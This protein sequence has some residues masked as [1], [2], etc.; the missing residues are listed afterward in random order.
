LPADD[1]KTVDDIWAVIVQKMPL[2]M[3]SWNPNS[4]ESMGLWEESI[5]AIRTQF[6]T[7]LEHPNRKFMINRFV[8]KFGRHGPQADFAWAIALGEFGINFGAGKGAGLYQERNLQEAVYRAVQLEVA[9]AQ[10]KYFLQNPALLERYCHF[11]YWGEWMDAGGKMYQ[12]LKHPTM[13][14]LASGEFW[15][16]A[17]DFLVLKLVTDSPCPEGTTPNML[18]DIAVRWN[19]VLSSVPPK[20]NADLP[21]PDWRGSDP[22][23]GPD[24]SGY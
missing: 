20:Y 8:R 12:T 18:Y 4:Q 2:D 24:L 17:R 16:R 6:L 5:L 3:P 10:M 11:L 9:E 19:E 13:S 22:I 14:R 7:L 15:W 23:P 1:I 21:F